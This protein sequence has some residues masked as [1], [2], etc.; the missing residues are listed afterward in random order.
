MN[1]SILINLL[2]VPQVIPHEQYVKHLNGASDSGEGIVQMFAS[3]SLARL[4]PDVKSWKAAAEALNMPGPMGVRCAR[5]CSST[6]TTGR[7]G[8]SALAKTP[9]AG[10][11]GPP[12]RRSSTASS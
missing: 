4:Q 8:S 1:A 9:A 7:P 10:T 12:K 3:L 5:A 6:R 2:V 11:I